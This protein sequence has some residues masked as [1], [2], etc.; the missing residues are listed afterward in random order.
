MLL[1]PNDKYARFCQQTN[2]AVGQCTNS[3]TNNPCCGPNE[4]MD[5][6]F[7]TLFELTPFGGATKNQDFTDISTN[8][9]TG[10]TTPPCVGSGPNCVAQNANI[11]FSIPIL[12]QSTN[13]CTFTTKGTQRNSLTCLTADCS[14]AYQTPTDDKQ[15][16]CPS[17]N[18]GYQVTFCP[19]PNPG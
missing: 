15:M 7:G 19:S 9:G 4:N 12:M 2:A 6:T 8:F 5:G 17:A 13:T 10:P 3:G 11:F 1:S 16:T 18:A 14:D